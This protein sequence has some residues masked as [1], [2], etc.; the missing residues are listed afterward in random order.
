M[1]IRLILTDIEGCLTTNKGIA[2]NLQAFQW[3]REHLEK[4]PSIALCTGRSQPYIEGILQAIGKFEDSVGEN[5]CILYIMEKDDIILHPKVN[6]ETLKEKEE[7]KK[8]LREKLEGKAH[9]EPGK[10]VCVSLYPEGKLTVPELSEIT[11][12]LLK[13]TFPNFQVVYSYSAVDITPQGIDKG[14]GMEMLVKR[15][16]LNYDEILG[17]G[18][19]LGDLPFLQKLK[20]KATPANG[21]PTLKSIATYTAKEENVLGVIEI[22]KYFF[23]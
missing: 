22:L 13:N 23:F 12:E 20:Y 21:H 6:E 7:L 3:I 2:L 1:S 9:I 4:L 5:G 15:K 16:K 19:S 17:I 10:E 18:D 11:K 8:F 14:A